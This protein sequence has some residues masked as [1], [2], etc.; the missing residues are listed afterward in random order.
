VESKQT[1]Q[2]VKQNLTC[3]LSHCS[4]VCVSKCAMNIEWMMC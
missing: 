4:N 3:C 2:A 1:R